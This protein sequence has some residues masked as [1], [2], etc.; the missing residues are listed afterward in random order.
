MPT[1]R[2]WFLDDSSK[3]PKGDWGR[4]TTIALTVFISEDPTWT[5]SLNGQA[6]Q[7]SLLEAEPS[8]ACTAATMLSDLSSA[9]LLHSYFCASIPSFASGVSDT[10]AGLCEDWR[11]S[12]WSAQSRLVTVIARYYNSY[13]AWGNTV[14]LRTNLLWV[15]LCLMTRLFITITE[16]T[17]LSS[18]GMHLSASQ[19][20]YLF[21]SA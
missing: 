19:F 9:V 3:L 14:L 10:V 11:S 17:L 6:L 12:G 21:W 20:P 15:G 8:E 16:A 5:A 2:T 7:V 4:K 1:E 13:Q 18:S